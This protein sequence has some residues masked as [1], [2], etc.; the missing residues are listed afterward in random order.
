MTRSDPNAD[1][2]QDEASRRRFLQSLMVAPAA[3][4]PLGSAACAATAPSDQ[5]AAALG[6]ISSNV[7]RVMPA[8]IEGPYYLD[9]K[10]VR[11]DIREGCPGIPLR[12]QLQVVTADCRPVSGARVDIW[13]C[14]AQGNYS[15]FADQGSDTRQDSRAETYLR[16]TQPTDANGIVTFETIYPGWYRGRTTHI[17]YKIFLNDSTVLTSQIFF[18]DALSEYVFEQS[19]AY[20]RNARRDTLNSIDGIAAEAGEGA[21]AAIREQKDRYI[22]AL[23]VGIDPAAR[24][25]EG[26]PGGR[27]PGGPGGP[28]PGGPGNRPPGPPPGM[29]GGRPNG[30][31]PGGP[32]GPMGQRTEN[33]SIF[34]G[35]AQ[36]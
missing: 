16:G 35:T 31:P 32:G 19:P 24:W 25:S 8:T 12:M 27:G 36:H 23:V 15:G 33:T 1:T 34:P 30:P 6:L 7:C 22:A 2:P 9:P 13:H 11:P 10:L 28:P 17:H 26:G 3:A 21:Y 18:P 4:L 14:D 5:L 20:R 29:G